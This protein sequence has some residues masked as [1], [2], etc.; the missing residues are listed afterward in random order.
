MFILYQHQ[1]HVSGARCYNRNLKYTQAH[2]HNVF[3][4]FMMCYQNVSLELITDSINLSQLLERRRRSSFR[5]RRG[6]TFNWMLLSRI[7][8]I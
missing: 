1:G 3:H 7:K 6:Q 2:R 8:L 4:K 5:Y